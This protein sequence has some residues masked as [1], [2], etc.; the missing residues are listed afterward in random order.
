MVD[1]IVV[2]GDSIAYGKWDSDGG[3]VAQLRKYIDEKHNISHGGNYQI[4]NSSI[5]GEIAPRLVQRLALEANFRFWP[6]EK[7]FAI[8]AVGLNDSNPGNWMAGEQTTE[9]NFKKS[10]SQ[11]IDT[12]REKNIEILI[13]GLTPVVEVKRIKQNSQFT[14]K[15]AAIY[16]RYLKEVATKERVN[17]LEMNQYLREHGCEDHIVDGVHLDHAGHELIFSR[18]RD[19]L[20]DKHLL[21]L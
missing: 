21:G 11:I 1:K 6:E 15:L 14:E 7:N 9:V 4:F 17:Y 10:I 12:F 5:P 16:D 3:W 18:V 19:Y 13:L 8:I 2:F 20:E